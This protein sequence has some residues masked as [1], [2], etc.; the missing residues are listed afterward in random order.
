MDSQFFAGIAF[1]VLSS[2]FMGI[3]VAPKKI[4]KQDSLLF[5]LTMVFGFFAGSLILFWLSGSWADF[6][7]K[8]NS[9]YGTYSVILGA[10]WAIGAYLFVA[11]IG[12][13]GLSRANPWKNLSPLF[14]ILLG[15]A[16]LGEY[17]K[18]LPIYVIAGGLLVVF[19]AHYLN[20]IGNEKTGNSSS[21]K[22]GGVFL[23]ILAGFIFALV[24]V[25]NKAAIPLGVLEQQ[26]VWSASSFITLTILSLIL[27]KN[28]FCVGLKDNFIAFGAGF[29]YLGA[30]Y[31]LLSSFKYV[32]VSIAYTI[33]QANAV[34]AVA[35]GVLFFHEMDA[36]R[37][38][39]R[40]LFGVL[41]GVAGV[42]LLALAK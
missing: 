27:R 8:V 22:N 24:A 29:I 6:F 26:V 7:A 28:V 1:A 31:F 33:V 9:K 2:F 15:F 20:R 18:V 42:L 13:I 35:V 23:A 25:L 10:M 34:W 41:A 3:Y 30:S 14:G 21:G 40:I 19:S 17:S 5:S 37:H 4:A 16:V 38:K 11:S 36:K 32:E 12:R 39:W